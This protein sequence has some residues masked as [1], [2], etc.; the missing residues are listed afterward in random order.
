MN[1]LPFKSNRFRF[2]TSEAALLAITLAS[3]VDKAHHGQRL[4]AI[5]MAGVFFPVLTGF[6][7]LWSRAMQF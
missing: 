2:I 5:L 4:A 7:Y 3:V 6:N 1:A